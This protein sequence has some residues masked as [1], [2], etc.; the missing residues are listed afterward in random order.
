VNTKEEPPGATVAIDFKRGQSNLS[1]KKYP[2]TAV[3]VSCGLI[4]GIRISLMRSRKGV[5]IDV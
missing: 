3:Y 1:P 5:P 4:P 2:K